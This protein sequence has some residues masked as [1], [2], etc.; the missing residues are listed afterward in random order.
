MTELIRRVSNLE[1]D[2]KAIQA[3]VG[4]IQR[5]LAVAEK[6]LDHIVDGMATKSDITEVKAAMANLEASLR[7]ELAAQTWKIL[8]WFVAVIGLVFAIARYVKP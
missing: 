1:A 8:G 3:D 6:T 4:K 2:V 7:K 5:D